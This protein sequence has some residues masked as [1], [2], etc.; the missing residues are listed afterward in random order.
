MAL[1]APSSVMWQ[2]SGSSELRSYLF[3]YPGTQIKVQGEPDG[4][5][6]R[7]TLLPTG[8]AAV[9]THPKGRQVLHKPQDHHEGCPRT[10][11]CL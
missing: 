2:V 6:K 8:A 10:M 5:S 4:Q 11:G 1:Q 9:Q 7:N 3:C